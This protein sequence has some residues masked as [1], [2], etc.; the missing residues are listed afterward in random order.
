MVDFG[1]RL[2][3]LRTQA[4]LTQQQLGDMLGLSKT[5]VSYYE[6]HTRTPSPD[7]L[8]RLAAVFHVSSDYLLGIDKKS[9]RTIDVS[10]L[11][12]EEVK[13]LERM[14]TLLRKKK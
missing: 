7:V 13:E 8:V 9:D 3:E 1:R 5:V 4:G 12:D 14:V 10:G 2:K 6:L 11:T